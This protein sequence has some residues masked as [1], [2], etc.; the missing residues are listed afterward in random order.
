MTLPIYFKEGE[1][2]TLPT[3]LLHLIIKEFLLAFE[4][5]NS[6]FSLENYNQ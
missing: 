4:N 3:T 2:Q 6:F 1:E 5:H